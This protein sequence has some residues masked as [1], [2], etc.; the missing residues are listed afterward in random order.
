MDTKP[1]TIKVSAFHREEI[2]ASHANLYV[3]VKGSSLVSGNE[4][5]KKA[6]EVSQ[7][8]EALTHFGLSPDAIH[9]QGV[10][11]EA[12]SGTL[13]KSSSARYHLKVKTEKLE[14][15]TGL[16]DIIAEQKNASLDRIEWKYP[17]DEAREQ[18]LESAIAK[19]KAKAEKVA[20]AMGVKL[21]G[22]Y[23]FMENTFDEE[24][25]PMPYQ[26][27]EMSM[28]SRSAMADQP[29]LDMEVQH[30]KTIHVNVDIWYRISSF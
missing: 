10:H 8:V 27:M 18:G 23:D 9:L 13:L 22:V 16:L 3:T 11:I 25:P 4:A 7:L 1:D 19:G 24:R 20:A 17:E 28:K 15:L 5:M 12:A 2:F 26:A 6:R 30:S 29:S 14:Q 21:L